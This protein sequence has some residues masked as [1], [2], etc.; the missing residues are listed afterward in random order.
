MC[1]AGWILKQKE[2][3]ENY[4]EHYQNYW[5]NWNMNDMLDN[6]MAYYVNSK[7]SE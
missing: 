5:E 6:R 4:K 7:L 2:T 3:K 1:N